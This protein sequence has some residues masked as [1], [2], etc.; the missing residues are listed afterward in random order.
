MDY[1]MHFVLKYV[2]DGPRKTQLDSTSEPN[3]ETTQQLSD[4]KTSV[5]VVDDDIR[6]LKLYTGESWKCW[7]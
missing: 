1:V 4:S 2:I 5:L 7:I 6:I 3:S